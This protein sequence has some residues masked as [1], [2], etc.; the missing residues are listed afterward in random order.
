MADIKTS[1]TTNDVQFENTDI[2]SRYVYVNTGDRTLIPAPDTSATVGAQVTPLVPF[3]PKNPNKGANEKGGLPSNAVGVYSAFPTMSPKYVHHDG[4]R[5][6]NMGGLARMYIP[7]SNEK[8]L[9]NIIARFKN[10]N[11]KQ[12]GAVA[13]Q[14]FGRSATSDKVGA[15]YIDFILTNVSHSLQEKF[16][17]SEV[18]EDNYVAFFFGQRAPMWNFSGALM[19]TYQDDWTMNMW[20]LYSEMGRGSQLAKLGLL[21]YIRYDSVIVGGGMVGFNWDL[22]STNELYT[23]FS[24]QFLVKTVTTIRGSKIAPSKMPE[25]WNAFYKTNMNL[26]DVTYLSLR[27]TIASSEQDTAVSSQA[28]GSSDT[29]TED[30]MVRDVMP[31]ALQSERL[32]AE[33][34]AEERRAADERWSYSQGDFSKSYAAANSSLSVSDYDKDQYSKTPDLF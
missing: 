7:V 13:E 34:A 1:T 15:G 10:K 6:A 28:A 30:M 9:T 25:M 16:Q 8:Y 5:A 26:N 23:P 17:V 22:N 27:S 20:R 3:D 2:I 29:V 14:L 31:N 18:L 19:N 32:A 12:I 33:M 4:V 21:L 11:D 24:F